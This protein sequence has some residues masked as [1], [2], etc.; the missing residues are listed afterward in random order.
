MVASCSA[1]PRRNAAATG[2]LILVSIDGFRWDYFQVH[3]APVLQKLAAQGVH[4]RRLTPCFPS[5]T[6]PNHYTL[7]TGLR[8]ENHGIVAN[9]FYDPS[10][11]AMFNIRNPESNTESRGWGGEPVWVTAEK[12]G[13]SSASFF[14]PG[15][16]A[17]I[18]GRRPSFYKTFDKK[19][20]SMQRVD[21][22]LAWLSLPETQRPRF[23]TLYFDIVDTAGHTFGPTAPETAAAVREVDDA[24]AHLLAGLDRL[25]L[26]ERANLVIVSDHGMS[27]CGPDRII[28]LED[29][30]DVSKV[31]VESTGPNGGVRPLTGSAADLVASERAT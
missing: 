5:K 19:L 3:Q 27:E 25:G 31:Q 21:G 22:L 16:E 15:S 9:W 13:V 14:W 2:P 10:F 30:M 18:H 29:L 7:V 12:Q 17:K 6:F 8:P 23:S 26:G 20:T 4:A 28:F 11:S 1:P 24:V